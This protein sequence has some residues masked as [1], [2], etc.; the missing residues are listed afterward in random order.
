MCGCDYVSNIPSVGHVTALTLIKKYKSIEA[1]LDSGKYNDKIEIGYLEKV[2]G[3]RE[4]F[5]KQ[6]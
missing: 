4:I 5:S 3:A 1:V 2:R 6:N